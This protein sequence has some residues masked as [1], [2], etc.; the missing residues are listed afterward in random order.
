MRKVWVL[1]TVIVVLAFF[2]RIYRIDKVPP[3][4]N[5]D[6]V[7]IGYNAYSIMQT[8]RDEWGE[9]MPLHFKS[10]G[11][12]KLPV[13]VY[14]SIPGIWFF[15]L[16]ELGVRV[17]P[18]LY[19]TLS[20]LIVFFLSRR[21][22]DS[23]RIGLLTALMVAISPWHIQLTRASFESSL[24]LLWVVLG[25]WCWI[26]GLSRRKWLW[27]LAMVFFVL[28]IY[29]YN[30]ERGFVPLL[31]LGLIVI[32]RRAVW[33]SKKAFIV[34]IVLFGVLLLPLVPF[35][36]S[37]EGGA[38][39]KLVS[40]AD[41]P[42]LL[43]R[44]NENRGNSKLPAPIARVVHSRYTYVVEKVLSNYFAHFD[45]RFLFVSGAP[46]KQHH[47]QN[48]GEMYWIQAPFFLCGLWLIFKFWKEKRNQLLII[49]VSVAFVPAALTNDSIPHALR[50]LNAMPALNMISVY[51]FVELVGRLKKK[52][53]IYGLVW[54]LSALLLFGQFIFYYDNFQNV[55]SIRYS[56]DWQYG[57]KQVVN[58]ITEHQ[59]EYDLVVFSRHYGEPHMFTL[60]FEKYDPQIF[61][62]DPKLERFETFDWVR[63][64]R[65][66][67]YYF[68]D[69]GDRGTQFADIVNANPDKKILFIGRDIDF[70]DSQTTLLNVKFLNG[71]PAFRIVEVK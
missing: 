17:T 48:I 43:P 20:V 64:L 14:A 2:L 51:G 35:V 52:S 7:S 61:I 11:E 19:G 70:P 53:V 9:W 46:H 26:E 4:L 6:E 23:N 25:L 24:A 59:N 1:L 32:Y 12:Y 31:I 27:S 60:F 8:G 38:R 37:G 45:P 13:Q 15:G 30:S 54:A 22:F 41:D 56:R 58:Y 36:L 42:G 18:V 55:Y 44:V 63:V 57:N 28:A 10:Y 69:L 49:W 66:G 71:D 67:K 33:Q 65:F 68:P 34:A 39:Y 50:T 16:N 40:V 21:L 3:S 62:N 5:W 29:T 47:P